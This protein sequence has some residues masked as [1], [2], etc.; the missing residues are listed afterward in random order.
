MVCRLIE[1]AQSISNTVNLANLAISIDIAAK[2]QINNAK[3]NVANI[4]SDTC[5]LQGKREREQQSGANFPQLRF[6]L[7]QTFA[8]QLSQI[9]A[10]EKS[11]MEKCKKKE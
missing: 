3:V 1:H 7:S 10:A 9:A 4:I 11:E 5:A 6:D 2:L 8:Q